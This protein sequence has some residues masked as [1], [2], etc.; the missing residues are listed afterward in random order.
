MKTFKNFLAE[1]ENTEAAI[2]FLAQK[3]KAE[4][5]DWLKKSGKR[6]VYRG[7][8]NNGETIELSPDQETNKILSDPPKIIKT[9]KDRKSKDASNKMH[10]RLNNALERA[11]NIKYRSEAVFCSPNQDIAKNYTG[12][13]GNVYSIYPRGEVNFVWSDLVS[14]AITLDG[15]TEHI[16]AHMVDREHAPEERLIEFF[17]IA[18]EFLLD[19]VPNLSESFKKELI[20]SKDGS[21]FLDKFWKLLDEQN[22]GNELSNDDKEFITDFQKVK[23]PKMNE[24][25]IEYLLDKY[26][27]EIYYQNKPIP[28]ASFEVMVACDD[29]ICIPLSIADEVHKLL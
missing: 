21:G 7:T 29:Y 4:C 25:F 11:F 2:Q 10:E 24:Q 16:F 27:D 13:Y 6:M 19:N 3:I 9:R 22:N 14:D 1:E 17:S 28:D 23:D 8:K 26:V 12:L 20:Q 5:T 18:R 15:Y